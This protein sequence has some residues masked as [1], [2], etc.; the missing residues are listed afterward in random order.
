M[1]KI[2]YKKFTKSELNSFRKISKDQN[3]IHFDKKLYKYSSF[4]NPVVYAALMLKYLYK[5]LKVI[6]SLYLKIFEFLSNRYLSM[7]I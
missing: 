1:K 4:K 2:I 5:M 6:K 3:P 7:K